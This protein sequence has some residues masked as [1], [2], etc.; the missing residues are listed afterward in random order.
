MGKKTKQDVEVYTNRTALSLAKGISIPHIKAAK[1]L[2]CDGIRP[3]GR[4]YWLEFQPWY[5]K[6]KQS[7][8]EYVE[9]TGESKTRDYWKER[10]EKAQA[11]IAEIQLQELQGNTLLRQKAIASMNQ[12]FGSM[13]IILRNMAQDLPHKLLGKNIT[14]L[15]VELSKAYDEICNKGLESLERWKK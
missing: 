6:N 13:A 12:V 8:V 14:D 4:I 11:L 7:I 10:K 5:E 3:N 2:G 15:Q 9:D 1:A